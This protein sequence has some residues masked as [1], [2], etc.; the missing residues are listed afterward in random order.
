MGYLLAHSPLHA[1]HLALTASQR[2]AQIP[3]KLQACV[4]CPTPGA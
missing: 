1:E 3:L 4:T 2:G